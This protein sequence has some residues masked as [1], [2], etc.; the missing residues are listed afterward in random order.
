LVVPRKS[1]CIEANYSPRAA[2]PGQPSNDG[3]KSTIANQRL[4]FS[5][6]PPME[7]HSLMTP[8]VEDIR[9]TQ[10]DFIAETQLPTNGGHYRVRA[11][12]HW[13]SDFDVLYLQFVQLY[14]IAVLRKTT[15]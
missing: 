14:F 1:A 3:M 11:Y 13:V 4:V 7:L 6:R 5:R 2:K 12:R 9:Y 8:V 15:K 10:T